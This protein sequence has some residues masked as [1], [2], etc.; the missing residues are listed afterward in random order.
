MRG[1]STGSGCVTRTRLLS[2]RRETLE[3]RRLLAVIAALRIDEGKDDW[4]EIRLCSAVRLLWKLVTR[5]DISPELTG[6]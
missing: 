3:T 2:H 6:W 5:T 4:P 1:Q